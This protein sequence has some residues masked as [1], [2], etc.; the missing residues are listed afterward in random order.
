M[1]EEIPNLIVLANEQNYKHF[2]ESS[3]SSRIN[4]ALMLKNYLQKMIAY[5]VK[6]FG[7]I[8]QKSILLTKCLVEHLTGDY[9]IGLGDESFEEQNERAEMLTNIIAYSDNDEL[10]DILKSNKEKELA[11]IVVD[12]SV[13]T[14]IVGDLENRD[15]QTKA[16]QN[17]NNSEE[18]MKKFF[19][20]SLNNIMHL[21]RTLAN[22]I[23]H[24]TGMDKE[25]SMELNH[26]IAGKLIGGIA[27]EILSVTVISKRH[28]T[29]IQNSKSMT[30]TIQEEGILHFSS[31]ATIEKIMESGKVKKSNA[32]VSDLTASKSF[33][34]A[35]TP[36]FED[37]LINIPAYDVMTAVRIKPTSEQ[38][39]DLK[40]RAINDRAVV[41]NGDFEFS[42]DR[43]KLL[44]LD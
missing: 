5:K 16:K 14:G 28:F 26:N 15:V 13:A 41:K 8:K 9:E 1:N 23:A 4:F 29:S 24:V 22:G 31:P 27:Y 43:Q 12:G 6:D 44:I 19:L 21:N 20:K 39:K 38:M 35:G 10:E 18:K 3:S 32:Y 33:F 40:Y 7:G 36:K 34:F 2:A 30:K 42:K 37:L 17:F 11:Q 25:K